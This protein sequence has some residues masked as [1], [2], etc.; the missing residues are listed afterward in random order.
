MKKF[1]RPARTLTAASLAVVLGLSM[2]ACGNGGSES[3]GDGNLRFSWWGSDPRHEATQEIIDIYESNNE[4]VTVAGE[5]SDFSG[6]W[7]KLATTTAGRDAPDVITMDEKYIME[8][9]GRGA[10]TDLT[11]L[12]NLDLSK[13]PEAALDLGRYEDGVYG[14]STGQNAYS[15][16]VNADLFAEAGVEIPDDSTWTWD[17]YYEISA[18]IS[19]NLGEVAG[20]DYGALDGDLRIWL[21]QNDEKLYSEDEPGTVG[22]SQENLLSWFEHLLHV[23]DT[24]GGVSAAQFTEAAAGTFEA[25]NFPTKKT[26][27]GWY[28]SNQLGAL[29]AATGD[30]IRILRVP[31]PSGN[32]EDNGMYYKASMYWSVSSQS[33]NQAAAADFVNFLANDPAAAEKMLVDRGVPANPEM[34]AAIEPKLD[35]S[36]QTVVSFLEE[37]EPEVSDSPKPSPIGAGTVQETIVR[38]VGEVLFDNLTP[39]EAT[40]QLTAEIEGMISAG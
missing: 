2:G 29:R 24:G 1:S 35:E 22:Y 37:I 9:A 26:A 28:W 14:L 18:T 40:E 17:D 8:Y 31:S 30:D 23:R 36:Q 32:A 34:A 16:M 25:E 12:E 10:L 21:R 27:M 3:A 15:V 19:E 39:E 7:D 33:D 13:F 20:T 6:Y 5:F 4:G 11:E 38:Y